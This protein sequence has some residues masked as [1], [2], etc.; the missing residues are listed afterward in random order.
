M[1]GT[2]QDVLAVPAKAGYYFLDQQAIQRGAERDGFPYVGTPLTEGFSSI[3]EPGESVNVIVEIEN[4]LVGYGD[5]TA[6]VY[7]GAA[8]RDTRF[9]A[10][11]VAETVTG[12]VRDA[13]IGQSAADYFGNIE[14]LQDDVPEMEEQTALQYGVSQALLDTAATA[15]R[16]AKASLLADEYGRSIVREPT[17]IYAQTGELHH[18][19]AEKMIMNGIKILPHGSFHNLEEVGENGEKLLDYVQWLSRRIDE[20]GPDA[21]SPRLHLDV[22]GQIGA[23]F[24]TPYDRDEVC[25]FFAELEEAASPYKITIEAPVD[26]GGQAAQIAALGGLRDALIES[27]VDVDI[28]V[29]E[30]CNTYEDICRFSNAEVVDLVQVKMPDLGYLHRS[31]DA[32]LACSD[33]ARAFLG[34]SANETDLSARASA[35]VALASDP[36][37]VMAKPG[38]D[39][40]TGIM[41]VRNEMCRTLARLGRASV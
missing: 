4:G 14:L 41:T 19:N 7:S 20:I 26:A 29:D 36:E 17:P 11:D 31:V 38:V 33:G 9:Y 1:V 6:V 23:A 30:W 16:Q 25:D 12:P 21:Y 5:C 39:V 32:V 40:D 15:T 28:A 3:S 18:R 34:G 2:I 10:E 13:L 8:G 27:N 24:G 22:Y 35:H 37:F